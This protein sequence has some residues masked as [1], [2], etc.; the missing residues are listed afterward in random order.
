MTL[1]PK[2]KN[3]SLIDKILEQKRSVVSAD[4]TENF[5]VSFQYVDATQRFASGY[6][7]WQKGGLLSKAL[8]VL[9]GYC[10]KPLLCQLDGD[11]FAIYGDF[12]HSGNTRFDKPGHVPE[13]AKW[14]RIHVNGPAVMVG[15]VVVD[16]LL[17]CLFG[18]DAQV[19]AHKEIQIQ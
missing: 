5:K 12:P 4:R 13:D 10:C 19:L 16:T 17:C 6:R 11:K 8:E 18:Q 2:T 1:R 3:K 9:Q 7:D 15:H 14:A